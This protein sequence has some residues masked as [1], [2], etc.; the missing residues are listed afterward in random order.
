[1]A[2]LSNPKFSFPS[3]INVANFVTLKLND[4]NYLLWETQVLSLIESQNLLCFLMGETIAPP[5]MST[6]ESGATVNNPNYTSWVRTDRLVKSWIMGTFSEEV[7]G[8]AVGLQ[9][10]AEVWTVLTN[11]I[12]QSSI[13]HLSSGFPF[14]QRATP[15]CCCSLPLHGFG[16]QLTYPPFGP[17][18]LSAARLPSVVPTRHLALQT[19]PSSNRAS[20]APAFLPPRPPPA[21]QPHLLGCVARVDLP[22]RFPVNVNDNETLARGLAARFGG[23]CFDYTIASFLPTARAVFF[24]NW[25]ARESAISR[26]PIRIDEFYF[27]FSSWVEI[28]EKERGFLHHKAW[29]CLLNWPILCWNEEDV[30]EA[31]VLL[32]P[33]AI[34]LMVEDR[35]FYVP[36]EI[37]SFEEH[38]DAHSRHWT[39]PGRHSPTPPVHRWRLG[40][41]IRGFFQ[42][43]NLEARDV[44]SDRGKSTLV[45]GIVEPRDQLPAPL[46]ALG[47]VSYHAYAASDPNLAHHTPPSQL[48]PGLGGPCGNGLDSVG[49]GPSARPATVDQ[50]NL[51]PTS[52]GS[53]SGPSHGGRGV[54]SVSAGADTGPT[55]LGH[56]ASPRAL[57]GPL[58]GSSPN[59]AGLTGGHP[60]APSLL[61]SAQTSA[62]LSLGRVEAL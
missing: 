34:D 53:L 39:A 55:V 44:R 47:S 10:A 27:C 6:S 9:T 51:I 36:I 31:D 12:K 46:L 16:T 28:E 61:P 56:P 29:I 59:S 13:A 25:V 41:P 26:S 43:S 15:L 19:G 24:P 37:E 48:R 2:S 54:L 57:S 22:A 14:C 60:L 33:E 11:H 45:N 42:N 58:T 18:G 62:N 5:K 40:R 17:S 21:G 8:Y 30:K 49:A 7:L 38:R 1:M 52:A 3:A 50:S 20:A 4:N 32:I 35:Q 23:S